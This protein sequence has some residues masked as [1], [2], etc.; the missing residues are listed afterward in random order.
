[1]FQYHNLEQTG[2]PNCTN[3]KNL[4][5]KYGISLV[6]LTA[7]LKEKL[8]VLM[9]SI[10]LKKIDFK[11]GS[12]NIFFRPLKN[13]QFNKI[14]NPNPENVVIAT[15]AFEKHNAVIVRWKKLTKTLLTKPKAKPQENCK[16]SIY[17]HNIQF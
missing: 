11:I 15:T 5:A 8:E 14:I 16:Y 12:T 10:G 17:D 1:M 2:F 9:H 4:L 6:D 3:Y 7:N 13:D